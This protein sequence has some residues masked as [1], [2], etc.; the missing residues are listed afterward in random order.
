M[1][2]N[3]ANERFSDYRDQ[4]TLHFMRTS[5]L[6]QEMTQSY[7][8]V[9]EHLAVGAQHLCGE[10]PDAGSLDHQET[11]KLSDASAANALDRDADADYDEMAELSSI[12]HD[13]DQLLGESPRISDLD[14]K[15][16]DKEKKPM[17]H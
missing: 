3:Q 6:V 7:R 14:V 11:D 4:V 17:A 10:H 13:L 9:Y 2:L 5:E 8:S 15:L 1:E 16:E 12:R